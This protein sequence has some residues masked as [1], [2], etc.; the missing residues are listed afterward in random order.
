MTLIEGM[1]ERLNAAVDSHNKSV[2]EGLEFGTL[3]PEEAERLRVPA[4]AVTVESVRN[5]PNEWPQS[6]R[7]ALRG[8]LVSEDP[9]ELIRM[10]DASPV[11]TETI[12]HL[13]LGASRAV[14]AKPGVMHGFHVG[15]RMIDFAHLICHCGAERAVLM[16]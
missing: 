9:N 2:D 16:G 12:R 4:G 7:N 3:L 11:K 15:L 10:A 8:V 5:G 14:G 1:I 13:R 6:L